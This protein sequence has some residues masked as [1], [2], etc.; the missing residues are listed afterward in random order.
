MRSVPVLLSLWLMPADAQCFSSLERTARLI[1]ATPVQWLKIQICWL[2][3][4]LPSGGYNRTEV[5]LPNLGYVDPSG[6]AH[7]LFGGCP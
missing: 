3:E 7:I 1:Q 2:G 4:G 6:E 5:R